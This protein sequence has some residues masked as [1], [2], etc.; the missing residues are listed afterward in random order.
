[1]I[2]ALKLWPGTTASYI[3]ANDNTKFPVKTLHLITKQGTAR[4]T[5]CRSLLF[6]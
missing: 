6:H 1:M 4:P 2:G 3:E 5:A